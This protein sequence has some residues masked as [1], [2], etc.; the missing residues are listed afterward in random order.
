MDYPS[1]YPAGAFGIAK[2]NAAPY[3]VVKSALDAAHRRDVKLGLDTLQHV[4]PWLQAFDLGKPSYGPEE[5]KQ[6]IQATYDAGYEGWVLWNPASRFD[7]FIPAFE[8]TLTPH[9][10]H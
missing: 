5:I 10:K 1:H 7:Q 3:D 8:K 6:Q 9:A 4:R 2:P